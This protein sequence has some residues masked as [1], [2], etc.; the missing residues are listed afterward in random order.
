MMLRSAQLKS[1]AREAASIVAPH[2]GVAHFEISCASTDNRVARLSYTSDIPCRGVEELKS[3]RADGFQIRIVT[4]RDQHELG[5][6]FEAGD[7]STEAVRFVLANA[8][9]ATIVDPHFAG[10]A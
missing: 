3:H 9:R 1:F 10:F 6:A 8:H 2:K 7:F 5:T 4:K